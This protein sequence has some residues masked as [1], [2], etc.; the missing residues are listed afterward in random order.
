MAAWNGGQHTN[1]TFAGDTLFAWTEVLERIDLGRPDIGALRLRLVA[2]K[3][4][5]PNAEEVPVKVAGDD[6]TER[7]NASVVLDLDY[8][9]LIPKRAVAA[10]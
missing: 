7:Y 9:G 2:C 8:V 5:D 4:V 6:G 3:N 1:P 10:Q